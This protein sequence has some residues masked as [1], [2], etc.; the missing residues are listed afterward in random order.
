MGS[1]KREAWIVKILIDTNVIMDVA[2]ERH[3]FFEDSNQVFTLVQ[4]Q[5]VEAY[6]SGSTF[7]DLYYLIRKNQ[8]REGSL[9]FLRRLVTICRVATV[10]QDVINRSL[11]SN[12]RDFEDAIQYHTAIINNLE[13]IVTRNTQDYREA[14]LQILTP[15]QLLEQFTS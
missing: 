2:L 1:V 12:F 15:T 8:G 6:V 9:D 10:N 7:G 4:Q 11:S 14:S 3:P 13:V 5:K